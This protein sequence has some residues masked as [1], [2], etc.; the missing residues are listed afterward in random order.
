MNLSSVVNINPY[1]GK[2]EWN[3]TYKDCYSDK[4]LK[5]KTIISTAYKVHWTIAPTLEYIRKL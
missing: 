3:T 1:P 5:W 4:I 2:T